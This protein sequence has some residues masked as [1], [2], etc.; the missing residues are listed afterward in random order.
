[1]RRRFHL[2]PLALIVLLAGSCSSVKPV[3]QQAEAQALRELDR[4]WLAAVTAKDSTA[5]A[6]YYA[7][8][9]LLFLPNAPPIEGKDPIRGW[10]GR[11]LQ[12]PNLT[13]TFQP[14]NVV[15]ATAGDMAYEVGTYRSAVQL[16]QGVAGDEGKTLVIWKK[17]NNEWK[18]AVDMFSSN[19]PPAPPPSGSAQ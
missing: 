15:V 8:D 16:P 19:R 7:P 1:M 13:L 5:V 3:N 9:A 6:S 4:K 18:V 2:I 14:S 11:F 10:W 12:I 17:V